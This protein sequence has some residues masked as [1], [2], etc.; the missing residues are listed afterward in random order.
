MDKTNLMEIGKLSLVREEWNWGT[1]LQFEHE[2]VQQDPHYSNEEV[3][4]EISLEQARE[5]IKHLSEF[6][7]IKES[8]EFSK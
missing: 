7:R 6:I 2:E 3:E 8:E 5:M 4:T 1:V